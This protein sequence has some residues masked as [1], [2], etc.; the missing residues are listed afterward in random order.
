MERISNARHYLHVF[1]NVCFAAGE[2]NGISRL[3]KVLSSILIEDQSIHFSGNML[4]VKL[5]ENTLQCTYLSPCHDRTRQLL[6]LVNGS[7]ALLAGG[8]WDL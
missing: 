5:R 8:L 2:E 3:H 7:K 4:M 1:V 6:P